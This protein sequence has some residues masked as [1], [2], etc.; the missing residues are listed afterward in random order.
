[1]DYLFLLGR[2]LYGG[3]FV[4]AGLNH[5]RNLTAMA[6]YASFRQ[7]PASK[8]AVIVS[9]LLILVGGLCILLG[10]NP[11]L[12]IICIVVFLVPVT[13]MM[14]PFWSDTDP[15]TRLSNRVNFE[16]NLALL[17]GALM[18][19]GVLQPWPFSLQL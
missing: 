5:F 15:Q 18:L 8:V 19:L 2:V 6:G 14:H 12:G 4:W 3:F 7:V 11:T 13:F 17:G 1:M 9:G 16:K 10:F